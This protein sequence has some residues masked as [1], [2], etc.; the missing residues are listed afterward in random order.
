[1]KEVP[2]GEAR[3]PLETATFVACIATIR[4][5]APEDIPDPTPEEDPA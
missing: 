3:L 1:M 2:L 5:H 4:E